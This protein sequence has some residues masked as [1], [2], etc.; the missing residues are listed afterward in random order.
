[1]RIF[2]KKEKLIISYKESHFLKLLKENDVT[3]KYVRWLNDYEIVKY[4]EQRHFKHSLQTVKDF[5]REKNNSNNSFLFGIFYENNHIGNIKLGPVSF[6]NKRSEISYF[7]G[8]KNLWGKG[9][10]SKTINYLTLISRER[11]EIKKFLA[12]VYECNL[13]SISVL[14]KN[15]FKQEGRIEKSVYFEGKQI[16]NLLYG[17]FLK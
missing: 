8:E 4:T 16:D 9:I 15:N 11:G 13:A 2:L 7:I 3:P 5:V 12:G 1:M 6:K 14:Q 17:K 10:V